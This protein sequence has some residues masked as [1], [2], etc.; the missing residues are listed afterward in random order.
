MLILKNGIEL[1]FGRGRFFIELI[2]I[3]VCQISL[4][5]RGSCFVF[6]IHMKMNVSLIYLLDGCVFN[7]S[8]KKI[9]NVFYVT[10]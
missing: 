6:L 8:Q 1:K 10:T 5:F 9:E 7:L 4:I 3:K 2:G